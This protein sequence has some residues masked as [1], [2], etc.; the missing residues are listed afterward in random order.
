LP[1]TVK[2]LRK[3]RAKASSLQEETQQPQPST[4]KQKTRTKESSME[5]NL[6]S[7]ETCEETSCAVEGDDD[8]AERDRKEDEDNEQIGSTVQ[9]SRSLPSDAS[10]KTKKKK[11]QQQ[12]FL[13]SVKIGKRVDK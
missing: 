4:L 7:P 5:R 10:E 9:N 11:N 12:A 6:L 2:R 3:G 8:N 1:T 13:F